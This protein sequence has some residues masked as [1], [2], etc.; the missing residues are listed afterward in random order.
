MN[1]IFP[2]GGQISGGVTTAGTIMASIAIV[3]IDNVAAQCTAGILD[4]STQEYQ[5]L[6]SLLTP[7]VC[8]SKSLQAISTSEMSLLTMHRSAFNKVKF[9][10][11]ND[12]NLYKK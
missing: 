7:K 1:Y 10:F 11:G 12:R 4:P 5:D 8:L 9:C 6:V 3:S 2:L